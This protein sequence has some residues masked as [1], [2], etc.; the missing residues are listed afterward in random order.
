MA[1]NNMTTLSVLLM[2]GCVLAA[3]DTEF[4]GQ[5]LQWTDDDGL[6]IKIIRPISADKCEHKSEKGDLVHQYFKLSTKEGKEIGSNFGGK[7]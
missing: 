7:P 2:L 4:Q 6:E 1:N 5:K 3:K